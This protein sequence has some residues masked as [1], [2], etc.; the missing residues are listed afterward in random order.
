MTILVCGAYGFLGFSTSRRLL[1]AGHS[2]VGIDKVREAVSPKGARIEI[3]SHYPN[4]RF[5]DVNMADSVALNDVFQ[6][7]QFEHCVF[8]GGQYSQSHSPKHVHACIEGNVVALVN[9]FEAA[10]R[11]KLHRVVYASSTFVQDGVLPTSFYGL[12]KEF[13]ER[14]ASVYTAQFGIETIGLRFGSVYGPH[15]RPDVGIAH[16]AKHLYK[17][18]EVDISKGAYAYRVAFLFIDDAVECVVRALER[19]AAKPYQVL[20]IVAEDDTRDMTHVLELLEKHS[21]RRARK[22]G[23][24]HEQ[25]ASVPTTQCAA[26]RASLGYAPSTKM[27]DGMAAFVKWYEAS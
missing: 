20:T 3:L 7:E 24:R 16:A 18:H 5:Y 23:E 26:V 10:V 22:I 15:I 19:P 12:T 2:V 8:L 6:R 11:K 13:A 14:C 9:L 4:F 17:G 25:P 21:G 27:D 1:D